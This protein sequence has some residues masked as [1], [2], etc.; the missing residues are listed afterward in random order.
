MTITV[1]LC[2]YNRCLNLTKVLSSLCVQEPPSGSWEVLVV[3]NNSFDRT[4]EVVEDFCRRYPARFRYLFEAQPGKSYALNTGIREARGEVLA[5]VDDDVAVEPTWL[6]N[7]TASL[8]NGDWAGA[9]GRILPEWC[10]APPRWLPLTSRYPFAPFA[11]FDLGPEARPLS[12]A[13]FGTNMAFRKAMFEKY[14]GFRTDLGPNPANMIRSEDTEFGN[15]LL[16]AGEKLR[17]EP[18]A[19]VYHPVLAKRARK[20]YFLAW[21]FHKARA[22]IRQNGTEPGRI[23]IR[24][25]PII[26]FR[27]LALWTMRWMVAFN[28]STRFERKINVWVNAGLITESYRRFRAGDTSS[29]AKYAAP[30]APQAQGNR[31]SSPIRPK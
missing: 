27:R 23:C 31:P 15:R 17:Y 13:P 8:Q 4:R 22:E 16:A 30:P 11:L 21:W 18:T 3:D 24:G 29:P 20:E 6:R 10:C 26:Y 1:I 2:T 7:L 9:G 14:G 28:P 5:F 12:E 25:V 19:V